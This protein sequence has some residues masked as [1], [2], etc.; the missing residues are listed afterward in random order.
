[1]NHSI[2]KC[3]SQPCWR[4]F[5]F[6]RLP[7][8]LVLNALR[9]FAHTF[10]LQSLCP[11]C[12]YGASFPSI[13][14]PEL[15]D[16]PSRNLGTCTLLIGH[17][18]ILCRSDSAHKNLQASNYKLSFFWELWREYCKHLVV[19]LAACIYEQHQICSQKSWARTQCYCGSCMASNKCGIIAPVL[20]LGLQF[21]CI[22]YAHR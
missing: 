19:I 22:Y 3:I 4:S 10:F 9:L 17:S 8:D 5:H 21:S 7:Q 18:S 12:S 20:V 11:S 15:F 16:A 6:A 1:M 14:A 2:W 13:S